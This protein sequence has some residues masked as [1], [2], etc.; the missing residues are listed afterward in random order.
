MRQRLFDNLNGMSRQL[1]G[2]RAERGAEPVN[3]NVSATHSLERR[4]HGHI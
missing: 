2:L 3:G 4:R 1:A